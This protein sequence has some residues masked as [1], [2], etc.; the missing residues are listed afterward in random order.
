MAM[1]TQH[2]VHPYSEERDRPDWKRRCKCCGQWCIVHYKAANPLCDRCS[3]LSEEERE[4]IKFVELVPYQ[5][6]MVVECPD[7]EF[8]YRSGAVFS[9][10]EWE[11]M[12]KFMVL[13][14]GM[15]VRN[16]RG[17]V[18]RVLDNLKVEVTSEA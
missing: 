15:V 11:T 16:G 4:K 7:R 6:W 8:G 17:R 9:S 12:K 2:V 18:E 1:Q 10:M 14:P 3:K 5:Y 13:I